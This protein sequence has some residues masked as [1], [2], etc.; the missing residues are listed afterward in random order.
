MA[1]WS[2][3]GLEVHFGYNNSCVFPR[4]EAE[5]RYEDFMNRLILT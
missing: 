4:G 5:A 1:Q 2:R 3:P